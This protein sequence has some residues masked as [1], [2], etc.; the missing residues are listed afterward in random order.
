MHKSKSIFWNLFTSQNILNRFP[1]LY[2]AS[3]FQHT[4]IVKQTFGPI[5]AAAHVRTMV[6]IKRGSLHSHHPLISHFLFPA[7]HI[8]DH[9]FSLVV[10]Q[11]NNG[12]EMSMM[13]R[14]EKI[15]DS[16]DISYDAYCLHNYFQDLVSC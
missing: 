4:L 13:S 6:L 12:P 8:W 15:K 1:I 3:N 7:T 2:P 9:T 5:I 11:Q 16:R 14:V 10:L